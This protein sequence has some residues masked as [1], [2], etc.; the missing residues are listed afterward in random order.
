VTISPITGGKQGKHADMGFESFES[1]N[2]QMNPTWKVGDSE[3]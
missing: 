1:W 2:F 3:E